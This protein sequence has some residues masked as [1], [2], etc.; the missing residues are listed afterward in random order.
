MDG[1]STDSIARLAA[2]LIAS[3]AG[4][5]I[6]SLLDVGAPA[7]PHAPIRLDP[8]RVNRLLG[9]A[10]PTD[11]IT[12][13]LADIGFLVQRLDGGALGVVAPAWRHDV[14]R[15]VDL[16]EEIARL[17]G[18]DTLPDD[19]RPYRIGTVPDHPLYLAG[20]RV[21]CALVAAG[22]AETRPMPFTRDDAAPHVRVTNPLADDEPFL[23]TSLLE[24]LTR[25]A[26]HN[27]N[28]HHGNVRLFEI[29]DVFAP[30]P[31]AMPRE[32]LRAAALVLG[33]RRPAHFTESRPPQFDAWDVKAL[34]E[35]MA[36]AAFPGG[37]IVLEP[38]SAAAAE[39]SAS[40][41]M[42]N[43][44][45]EGRVVGDVRELA[46][47]APVWASPAFGVE[48]TL[49]AMSAR[50]VAEAGSHAYALVE[51]ATGVRPS[52][53]Y[54]PLPSAPAAEFDLSLLVPDALPSESVERVIRRTAGDLLE[55]LVLFDQYKG[56]GVPSGSRS[57]AWR[58]TF[59]HPERTLRDKEIDG[60]RSQL[61]K[62]L[63]SELGVVPRTA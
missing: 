42:W 62:T 56:T 9:A 13:L 47:D 29:G 21:R 3:V 53:R 61:L 49:G 63:E 39:G 54:R 26:E 45:H 2:G 22:L 7:Q 51:S 52:I 14:A 17:R 46:L 37:T 6:T 28:Q 27:L 33:D 40:G 15:D 36:R 58:L 57:L 35:E 55:S 38:A 1:A 48:I 25:R 41:L 18:Y 10:V 32:E 59:R 30:V 34:A 31:G 5:T 12:R 16:V 8:Q 11:E 4:G 50:P 23:R 19:L 20:R 60:R 24:T 43:V 44:L